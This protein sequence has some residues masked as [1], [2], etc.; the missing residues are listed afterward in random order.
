MSNHMSTPVNSL[1]V[2]ETSAPPLSNDPIVTDVLEEME[3][4]VSAAQYHVQDQPLK[5][6]QLPPQQVYNSYGNYQAPML[7]PPYIKNQSGS[8]INTTNM[9]MAIFASIIAV[10]ILIPNISFLYEKF[11]KLSVVKSYEMIIRVVLLALV[12][13]FAMSRLNI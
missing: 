7:M 9:Q 10:I 11:E 8:W 13:Y 4:E 2:A 5:Q 12:L 6:Q 1:P 3:R